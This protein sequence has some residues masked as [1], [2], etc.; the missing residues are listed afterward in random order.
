MKLTFAPK[1]ILQ[2]D[3]ARIVFRN[4]EGRASKYNRQGDR[5][6][7]LVIDDREIADAL[8][9]EGWNVRIKPPRE[10]GDAPFMYMLVK[11][12]FNNYG[13]KV[14]LKTGDVK[15]RLDEESV[16]CLDD[17]EIA[18]VDLDIRPYDW[19][20][21]DGK[22]GRT[23]YLQAI[24]VEQ[25]VDRFASEQVSFGNDRNDW[26]KSAAENAENDDLPFDLG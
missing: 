24:C 17:V 26:L 19:E 16:R 12:K 2:I 18:R 4:F 20:M 25:E 1:G 15:N 6:F 10:D 9:N 5:N 11:V 22:S 8:I 13:P 21:S 14:Y 7:A 3:D 23:A